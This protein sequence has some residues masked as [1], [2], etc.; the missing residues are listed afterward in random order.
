MGAEGVSSGAEAVG[1][2]DLL[3]LPA[4]ALVITC[5]LLYFYLVAE[6]TGGT[7]VLGVLGAGACGVALS[8]LRILRETVR[9]AAEEDGNRFVVVSVVSA[10]VTALAVLAQLVLMH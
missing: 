5:Q 2:L 1:H 6:Q 4:A 10:G 7:S 9:G 8:Y 3:G